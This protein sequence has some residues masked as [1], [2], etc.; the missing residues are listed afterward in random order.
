MA[1]GSSSPLVSCILPARSRRFAA[2]AIDYF[3]RQTWPSKELIILDDG[4]DPV[5]DL[6]PVAANLRYIRLETPHSAA[7]KWNL[8]CSQARGEIVLHWPETDWHAPGRIQSM[9]AA[10]RRR[11]TQVCGLNRILL[12]DL[13]AGQTWLCRGPAVYPGSLCYRR[14][15]GER[16]PFEDG[17]EHSTLRVP[18]VAEADCQVRIVNALGLEARS[19]GGVPH[20]T[21]DL[22]RILGD[23]W[24]FYEREL[25][26]PPPRPRAVFAVPAL[27]RP[28][29]PSHPLVSCIMPTHNRRRFVGLAI[30]YF[31]RQD[32]EP[33]ELVIVDDGAD[34]VEDLVPADSRIRYVRLDHKLTV[35]AKRNLACEHARGQVVIHWDDDDWHAPDRIRT[36]VGVLVRER[37][38]L[39]G[40]NP[41]FFLDPA[42][43]RAWRYLYPPQ[44]KFW[45]HGGTFCYRRSFWEDHRF[46]DIDVGEDNQFIW[47]APPARMIAVPDSTVLVALI[48]PG[49]VSPKEPGTTYWQSHPARQI[50]QLL[51]EDWNCYERGIECPAPASPIQALAAQAPCGLRN[52]FVC[53]VHENPECVVDLVRNLRCLDPAS[54][55]LLYDGSGGAQLLNGAFRFE[56]Y[57]AVLH[58]R[59]RPMVWGQLHGFAVDAMEFAL[60]HFQF[61]TLTIVDSDQLAV[62]Y[63]Y[64]RH[65]EPCLAAH[66]R[67][68]MLVNSPA[69][70][71]AD[72]SVGPAAAAFREIDLWRPYLRRFAGGEQKFVHWSYWPSTVF[73]ADAA[74][75]L[76]RLFASDT[77][78]NDI[79]RRSRIWATEEVL[80]PTLAALLGYEIAASPCSYAYVKYRESY[81]NWHIEAALR[82]ADVYWVHPVARKY[83]D[84]LRRLV[85]E[86]YSQYQQTPAPLTPA[87]RDGSGGPPPLL[88]TQPILARMRSIEG[89]LEE[90]EADLL[91]AAASRA[92]ALFPGPQN[93]VEVGSYCGRSTVV[94]GSVVQ[95]L[96]PDSRLYAIDPHDGKI[97][98]LDQGVGIE[99]PTFSRFQQNISTAGL[100]GVVEAV[101][102]HS[103]EVAWDRPIPFLFIDGLHDY[104]NVS[105]DFYHFEPF[106]TP[107]GF[108]AFHDYADFFPGVKCLVDE[109][110]AS[111]QYRR[112]G[113]A[114]SMIVVEKLG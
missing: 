54:I 82:E 18:G 64:S 83:E 110:L 97:G 91:V 49:N 33:K 68:G 102:K 98:S 76:T 66:S 27:E 56:R 92:L 40:L 78:L 58:P 52:I 84:P 80:F 5:E 24:S 16:H 88:L 96:S 75:D 48:H 53:L 100:A 14:V 94:I 31:L 112:L 70:Q 30:H 106:V 3:L 101:Q 37:A 8:G 44:E 104:P 47:S 87:P 21:E 20:P 26:A 45:V 6:V 13:A 89:W 108:I 50:R 81:S 72:T 107:G 103:Y 41:V 73:T 86:R 79:L 34:S 11:R 62:R 17:E 10:L 71:P 28:A 32:Y 22:R 36:Q 90:D 2:L 105:R 109:L 99:A 69:P 35:G 46:A 42:A 67:L 4:A 93:L 59:P 38:D 15:W 61:D 51:G 25:P 23:D 19:A 9:V 95:T 77:A 114:R 63:G 7:A 113:V 74:R 65:L 43:G 1:G 39:C 60:A 55:V 57:G 29:L 12:Y 85:R 111:G